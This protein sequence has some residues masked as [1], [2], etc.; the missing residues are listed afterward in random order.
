MGDEPFLLVGS[1]EQSK[2]Y[3]TLA[4]AFANDPVERW[5]YPDLAEYHKHF[6]D[7]LAAFGGRAFQTETVWRLGDFAAVALW[8]PPGYRS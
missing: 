7:F 1:D 6:P 5:L 8:L 2:V 4:S 3:D